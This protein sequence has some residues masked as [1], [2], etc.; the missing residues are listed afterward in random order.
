MITLSAQ[1]ISFV[2]LYVLLRAFKDKNKGNIISVKTKHSPRSSDKAKGTMKPQCLQG[3]WAL[4][5]GLRAGRR[6]GVEKLV[7]S[8]P[9]PKLLY[10]TAMCQLLVCCGSVSCPQWKAGRVPRNV[11]RAFA[12]SV[13]YQRY[14]SGLHRSCLLLRVFK[15]GISCPVRMTLPGVTTVNCKTRTMSRNAV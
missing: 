11:H 5:R 13:S 4:G 10:F 8:K 6:V 2:S 1:P 7:R 14:S 3:S 15:D 9:E 12:A